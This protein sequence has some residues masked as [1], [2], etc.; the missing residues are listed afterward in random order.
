MN[1]SS[2]NEQLALTGSKTKRVSFRF[3]VFT[4]EIM[5]EILGVEEEGKQ[6]R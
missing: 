6:R 3:F 1:P 5:E 4:P 2:S